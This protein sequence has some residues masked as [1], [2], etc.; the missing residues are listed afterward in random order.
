MI[1]KTG[2]F[3]LKD[4]LFGE[5]GCAYAVAGLNLLERLVGNY[6]GETGFELPADEL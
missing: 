2:R 5:N 6:K 4:E 3:H 1:G